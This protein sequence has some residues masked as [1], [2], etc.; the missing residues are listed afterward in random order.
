[1]RRLVVGVRPWGRISSPASALG[2][3]CNHAAGARVYCG[4]CDGIKLLPRS[5]GSLAFLPTQDLGRIAWIQGARC[6][7]NCAREHQNRP[8]SSQRQPRL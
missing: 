7:R 5:R 8:H 3:P 4:C 6:A 2:F 1:M